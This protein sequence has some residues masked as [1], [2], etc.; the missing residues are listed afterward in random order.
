MGIACFTQTGG[1]MMDGQ[2]G[3]GVR[4]RHHAIMPHT[5]ADKNKLAGKHCKAGSEG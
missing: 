5:L 3:E 2:C 1:E 4:S